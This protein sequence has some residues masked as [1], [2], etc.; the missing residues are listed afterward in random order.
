MADIRP[1]NAVRFNASLPLNQH[2]T[3]PYDKIPPELIE[4]YR[5]RSPHSMC[6]LIRPDEQQADTLGITKYQLAAQLFKE[7]QTDDILVRDECPG[8]YPYRQTYDLDGATYARS[9]FIGLCR[10]EEYDQ[11]I[12]FPHERTLSK[13]KADRYSLLE[14]G[15]VHYGVIFLLYEDD[16]SA[17]A[18]LDSCMQSQPV[19]GLTDDFSVKNELWQMT[20][21]DTIATLTGSLAD[22]QLFIADGHHRYETSLMYARNH[23]DDPRAQYTLAMFVNINSQLEVLPTH[24]TL[25]NCSP[26]VRNMLKDILA[27]SF[28]IIPRTSLED[29]L[30]ATAQSSPDI[31]IGCYD[32]KGFW[33]AELKNPG[34]MSTA[35]TDKSTDWQEL[36]VAVLHTLIIEQALEISQ[37]QV[38]QGGYVSYHR[39]PAAAVAR[40]DSGQDELAFFL[41]PTQPSQ[42]CA[43]ARNGEVMPQKSTDFYPKLLTGMAM[44]GMDQ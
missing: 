31:T 26:E 38:A 42:L 6:N 10:V 9:G 32:G 34:C 3:Q 4:T 23:A 22:K 27:K 2:V 7:W 24:R 8:L 5:Q 14:E 41:H 17:Q 16:G 13:P 39:D 1:F 43:V 15:R 36:D 33:T 20:D 18:C 35:A 12:V 28:T 29:V 44:Y 37:D 19:S 40:V 21:P 30:S 11:R 25:R